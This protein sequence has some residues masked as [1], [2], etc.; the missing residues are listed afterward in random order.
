MNKRNCTALVVAAT[1]LAAAAC[2]PLTTE[3]PEWFILQT[4]SDA[5]AEFRTLSVG[6]TR[7]TPS[8]LATGQTALVTLARP[9]LLRV[10]TRDSG[11]ITSI[12]ISDGKRVTGTGPS[13]AVGS[14]AP[15]DLKDLN[16]TNVEETARWGTRLLVD[17]SLVL[18]L[19]QVESTTETVDGSEV[20]RVSGTEVQP[21]RQAVPVRIWISPDS[22]LPVKYSRTENGRPIVL[23]FEKPAID[24][25]LAPNAFTVK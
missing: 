5:I 22:G 3:K 24:T 4:Y 21:G 15:A 6:I 17:T 20:V 16:L 2:Q 8:G 18:D 1:W 10:E 23:A 9:N 11:K 25:E 12:L 13:G 14:D 19:Q 7:L